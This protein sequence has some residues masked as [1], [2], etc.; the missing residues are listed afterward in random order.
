[1]VLLEADLHYT[2]KLLTPGGRSSSC[3]STTMS[4][5]DSAVD[6]TNRVTN[7]ADISV[8]ETMLRITAVVHASRRA[9]RACHY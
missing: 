6:I 9:R 2:H 3:L 7:T 8:I 4:I 5:A 1:M